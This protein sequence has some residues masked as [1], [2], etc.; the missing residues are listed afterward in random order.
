MR[1]L[2]VLLVALSI[3]ACSPSDDQVETDTEPTSTTTAPIE[4]TT[5]TTLPPAF[6]VSSPAFDP[7]G[8]IPVEYT[9]DGSDV[10]PELNV[11]GIPEG[12]AAIAVFVD[13]PDAPLGTWTHWLEFDI[14]TGSGSYDFPRDAPPAGVAGVNSW[15]LEGYMGPCPPAGE[16][17]TYHFAVFALDELLGLPSGVDTEAVRDAMDGHIVEMV[18]ITGIYSR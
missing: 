9:C 13:D 6:E 11:V 8:E 12:T 3:A 18:E 2:T 4:Q 16:E 1:R 17:H 7:G 15:H 10:S 5:T 14:P